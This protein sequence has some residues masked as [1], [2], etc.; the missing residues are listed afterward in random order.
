[1]KKV[2]TTG[3]ES[4]THDVTEHIVFNIL[5]TT[6]QKNVTVYGKIDKEGDNIGVFTYD[7]QSNHVTTQVKPFSDL[8]EGEFVAI[9]KD[10]TTCILELVDTL[11]EDVVVEES[12]E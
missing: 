12:E 1:M 4:F 8:T 6:T 9:F 5:K 2:V 11:K 3:N 7:K 10:V